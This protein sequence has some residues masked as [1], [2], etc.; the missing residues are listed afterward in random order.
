[1]AAI[2]IGDFDAKSDDYDTFLKMTKFTKGVALIRS[3]DRV[4]NLGRYWPIT[5]LS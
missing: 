3:K 5:G 1:M 4:T 2:F